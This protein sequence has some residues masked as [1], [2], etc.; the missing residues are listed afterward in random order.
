MNK[1]FF[2][3]LLSV[4]LNL[5]G[6]TTNIYLVS[7]N[8]FNSHVDTRVGKPTNTLTT[9]SVVGVGAGT[10]LEYKPVVIDTTAMYPTNDNIIS[11][12]GMVRRWFD[13][14]AGRSIQLSI[15][16]KTNKTNNR[17][18]SAYNANNATNGIQQ[19]SANI[20]WIGQ[21]YNTTS[22]QSQQV[23]L[24]SYIEPVQGATL[25]GS[26]WY[27][28]WST[29]NLFDTNY[30]NELIYDAGGNLIVPTSVASLSANFTNTLTA[31]T[32]NIATNLNVFGA[33]VLTTITSSSLTVGSGGPDR[34]AITDIL[35]DTA[36]LDFGSIVAGASADLTI[37]ITGVVV[38][39]TVKIGL[40]AAPAAGIVFMGFVSAADTVTIRAMNITA[41]SVDPASA[42]YGATVF[43]F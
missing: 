10:N 31:G 38:G 24:R 21:G 3:L 9:F 7:S 15:D 33:T 36:T 25:G 19:L 20:T 30:I 34:R 32:V 5:K 37:T 13:I 2:L 6:Q 14:A 1:I 42:T 11:L 28:G 23:A 4:C 17:G 18:I 16:S 40:P 29:N 8:T 22:N 12:G 43:K 41:L 26:K 35:S 27:L 39:N